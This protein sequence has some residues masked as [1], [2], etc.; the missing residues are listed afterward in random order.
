MQSSQ[1]YLI[2]VFWL[3]YI[4]PIKFKIRILD[5]MLLPKNSAP[6][7]GLY[8]RVCR[9]DFDVSLLNVSKMTFY[10]SLSLFGCWFLLPYQRFKSYKNHTFTCL[11][12]IGD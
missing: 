10:S 9:L 12:D 6:F 1:I 2:R 7:E 11:L 4:F 3:K 5:L 8:I